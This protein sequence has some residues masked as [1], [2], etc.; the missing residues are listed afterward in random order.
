M[1]RKKQQHPRKRRSRKRRCVKITNNNCQEK[2]EDEVKTLANFHMCIPCLPVHE[3]WPSVR[4]LVRLRKVYEIQKII[5][6]STE[7]VK[8][9]FQGN[10]GFLNLLNAKKELTCT[11]KQCLLATS[12]KDYVQNNF[13]SCIVICH[14]ID[15]YV[16][17]VIRAANPCQICATSVEP[18]MLCAKCLVFTL[19]DRC[20]AGRQIHNIICDDVCEILQPYADKLEPVDCC[21]GCLRPVKSVETWCKQKLYCDEECK[22]TT[23]E[24][25]I[26]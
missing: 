4:Q 20:K 10:Y 12:L 23:E 2:K 1:A 22:K 16:N 24:K 14:C 9:L 25:K 13:G 26:Y 17:V 19:C 5:P 11:Y 18:V 15:G 7:V 21:E 8:I 3:E 6:M